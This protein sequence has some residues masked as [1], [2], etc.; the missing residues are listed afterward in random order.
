[1]YPRGGDGER[2]GFP[3]GVINVIHARGMPS[4]QALSEHMD[5]RCISFTVSARTGRLIQA[6]ASKSNLKNVI[7]E[8]G[9]SH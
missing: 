1:M 5:V 8:L 7:L 3:P 6:A 2:G 4:G 9:G